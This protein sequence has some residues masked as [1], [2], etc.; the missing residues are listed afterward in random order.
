MS[1]AI[2]WSAAICSV[3]CFLGSFATF[4]VAAQEQASSPI[5]IHAINHDVSPPLREIV[6]P[7]ESQAPSRAHPL[8]HITPFGTQTEAALLGQTDTAVQDSVSTLTPNN[9][10]LTFFSGISF[11]GMTPSDTNGSVGDTQYVQIA[12]TEYVVYDKST[13]AVLHGPAPINSIWS[14]FGGLCE[15]NNG[16]DPIVLYDR[17]AHRWLVSQLAYTSTFSSNFQCLAI[18]TSS[19]ATGSY[20]RYAYNFGSNLPDYPKFGVWPDAYYWSSNTFPGGG[21]TFT[22]AQVCAF[23]RTRMLAGLAAAA[24]CFQQSSKVASLLPSNLD[25]STLPLAG[26]PN[27][28]LELSGSSALGLFKFHADFATPSNSTFTGPVTIPVAAFSLA[29]GGNVC[30]PQPATTQQLDSLGDRLMYR[31]AYRNFGGHESLVANHSV[32]AGSGVGVRWYEIRSPNATPTLYQQ[33]TYAPD[34]TFRWMGSIAMDQAGD[35]AVG[36]SASD[37]STHPAVR[38]AGRV[39]SDPLGTL[40][41]ESSIMEGTGSQVGDNRWGDYSGMSVDPVDDCTFWY[42]N[43]YLT[44]DGQYNWKTAIGSF[45][46]AACG[47]TLAPSFSL[48]ATTSSQSEPQGGSA[49][50]AITVTPSN[51]FS[52][53]VS[54]SVS[55]LPSGATAN[56]SPSSLTGSGPS[57]MTVT[58]TS[59][60]PV[61]TYILT[62]AGISGSLVRTMAVTLAVTSAGT[63]TANDFSISV[64]PSSQTAMGGWT[65]YYTVQVAGVNG[66]AFAG[67]VSLSVSGFPRRSSVLLSRTSVTGGGSST[68]TLTTPKS[69]SKGT[70][71]LTITGTSGSLVHSAT[72]TLTIN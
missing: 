15:T 17:I 58:T 44:T 29:C 12:N 72:A 8:H 26:E 42:T 9:N 50:Y 14:G 40:E 38:Y 6:L 10:L 28:F 51:G 46:F 60:T 41:S 64:S 48:S 34:S 59:A 22:G 66:G 1:K 13:G 31:L 69:V 56:F 65:S 37:S 32:T 20:F 30:V 35:I 49:N 24:V 55:G 54:F 4:P 16:G 27:F 21:N 67:T 5:V 71:T 3:F 45:K 33:G 18:S 57:T 2:R 23:D 43:Q 53:S 47:S 7:A 25:G 62:I 63:S 39:S 61:G 11:D 70:Y 36:Y 19:D 52:G 68:L